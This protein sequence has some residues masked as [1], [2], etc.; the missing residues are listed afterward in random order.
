MW[1]ALPFYQTMVLSSQLYFGMWLHMTNP[2]AAAYFDA[3]R[4]RK[5]YGSD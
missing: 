1:T 2:V 3:L 5:R 4:E